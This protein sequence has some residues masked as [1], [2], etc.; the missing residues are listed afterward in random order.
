MGR[1][2]TNYL[3][4]YTDAAVLDEI[5]RVAALA[6]T[7]PLT[8]T[9][10]CKLSGR[11]S[12]TTIRRRL[13]GW[14]EAL[15]AAGVGNLYGGQAVT[16]KMKDQLARRM[17]TE[18]LL[19]ELQR[20]WTEDGST[21]LTVEAFDRRSKITSSTALRN[22]FGSWPAALKRAGIGL[23]DHGKRYTDEECF[24][25]LVNVWTHYGRQPE[26][27]EMRL[28]PS[29]AG[30]K[31]YIVRWR[32]WRKALNAF[33]EW[34][35]ADES[36]ESEACHAPQA[37]RQLTLTPAREDRHEVPPKLRWKIIVRDRFRCVACGRSPANDLTVELHVDHIS[38]HA[39]GGRTVMENLQTLCRQCNLG[40]GK[41][42]GKVV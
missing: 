36:T 8:K 31:A 24:S 13:G 35:N 27:R 18:A 3:D 16:K 32:T 14:R 11:V 40:K 21:T 41:S 20:V 28:P 5:R 9:L 34:A 42:Y 22:R 15:V 23:A 1:F 33:V 17:S 38:P 37:E 2:R 10:F 12:L 4:S 25:N 39:D 26:Y 30:P 29:V 7:G 6:G 19:H